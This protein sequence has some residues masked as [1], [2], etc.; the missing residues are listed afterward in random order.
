MEGVDLE[1]PGG[2]T[3]TESR[4][5]AEERGGEGYVVCDADGESYFWAPASWDHRRG[6]ASREVERVEEVLVWV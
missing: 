2:W 4:T 5:G 3:R 6:R 1:E